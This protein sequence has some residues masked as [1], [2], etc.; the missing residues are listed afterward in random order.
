M[1]RLAIVL[2]TPFLGAASRRGTQ[3]R[4]FAQDLDCP[5]VAIPDGKHGCVDME[6]TYVAVACCGSEICEQQMHQLREEGALRMQTYWIGCGLLPTDIQPVDGVMTVVNSTRLCTEQCLNLPALLSASPL[7]GLKGLE[8]MCADEISKWQ[9]LIDNLAAFDRAWEECAVEDEISID[10]LRKTTLPVTPD[11]DWS[12]TGNISDIQKKLHKQQADM[13][14]S[15][16]LE[17]QGEPVWLVM[18]N[19][20]TVARQQYEKI[21][22]DSFASIEGMGMFATKAAYLYEVGGVGLQLAYALAASPSK[23]S[24]DSMVDSLLDSSHGLLPSPLKKFWRWL[25]KTKNT[26]ILTMKEPTREGFAKPVAKF[27]CMEGSFE[28]SPSKAFV[29]WADRDAHA[30]LTARHL[31][32]L[33]TSL[34]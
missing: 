15:C 30:H 29:M 16:P 8:T 18:Q 32:L 31:A 2:S 20:A 24:L 14:V 10:E 4:G 11:I 12:I 13:P 21:W 26:A 19:T 1:F 27:R 5:E 25:L 34:A 7:E 9:A 28:G 23:V 22:A 3:D 17:S 33:I 6:G